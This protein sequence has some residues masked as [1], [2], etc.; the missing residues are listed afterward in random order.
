MGDFMKRLSFG[1]VD[2]IGI[3]I[4]GF[5]LLFFIGIGLILPASQLL[6]AFGADGSFF[7]FSISRIELIS[8]LALMSYLV[9]Y[10]ILLIDM[11]EYDI[12]TIKK[13]IKDNGEDKYKLKIDNDYDEYP[14]INLKDYLQK[15]GYEKLNRY[16]IWD[17][18]DP[19]KM[20][21]THINYLKQFIAFKS[22]QLINKIE[23]LEANIRLVYGIIVISIPGIVLSGLGIVIS[24]VTLIKLNS[25]SSSEIKAVP[26]I[27]LI[28]ILLILALFI[29]RRIVGKQFHPT[30]GSELIKILG[31]VYLCEQKAKYDGKTK[32]V[33]DYFPF[34]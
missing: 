33:D 21:R 24:I 13:L 20:S 28:N 16:V 3:T 18:T 7:P 19:S 9:G 11:Q 10:F 17:K 30:R 4:P 29:A 27:I 26:A 14:Y 23:T 22:P 12:R 2:F 15:I 5:L 1:V 25:N 34:I 8:F 32:N 6:K 31:A